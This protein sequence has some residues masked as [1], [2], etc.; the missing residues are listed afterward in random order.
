MLVSV[1]QRLNHGVSFNANYTMSHCI[2]DYMSR[3]DGGYGASV[4]HTYQDPNNRRHD[5]SNCDIDQRHIFNLSALGE[6]PKFANRTLSMVGSGWRLSGIYRAGTAGSIV[7]ASTSITQRTVTLGTPAAGNRG[8][9]SGADQCL[10]NIDNQRPQLL[11]PNAVYLD[12]SGRPGSQWLNPAA[13]GLPSVGTLG[14]LGRN[15]LRL[16]MDWQF[17]AALSRVF[18]VRESQSLEFRAEA[19]N[20]LN[21]FRPGDSTS[22][23]VVTSNWT[24]AQFGKLLSAQDPRIM[25]FALKYLF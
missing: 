3:A 13:F 9:I 4:N 24:S 25:Q 11:L 22:G 17:N 10:C 19:F 6:T 14:N 15:T 1:Q 12:T 21:S 5:R 18:R 16:P 20:V 7:A 2:G 23:Q 8:V